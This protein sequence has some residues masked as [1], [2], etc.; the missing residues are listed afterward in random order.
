[1]GILNK[2]FGRGSSTRQSRA[3]AASISSSEFVRNATAGNA[4][5]LIKISDMAD[6]CLAIMAGFQEQ[7]ML[8][9]EQFQEHLSGRCPRCGV[10]LTGSGIMMVAMAKR[11]GHA[12]F[13]A[14]SRMTERVY[15]GKCA[16]A[17]CK[18]EEIVIEWQP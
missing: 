18:S 13:G 8:N 6:F 15:E 10:R 3:S 11:F 17:Q 9:E 5:S 4:R 1:M 16:N 14:G 12:A 7:G 2:I